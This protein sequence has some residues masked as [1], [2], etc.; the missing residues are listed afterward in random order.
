VICVHCK[1]SNHQGCKSNPN[2]NTCTHIS[3]QLIQALQSALVEVEASSGVSPDDPALVALKS[4]VLQ[5]IANLELAKAELASS[6]ESSA[7]DPQSVEVPT[8]AG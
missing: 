3:E 5:R 7:A 1:H 4:I 8:D 2:A 6:P